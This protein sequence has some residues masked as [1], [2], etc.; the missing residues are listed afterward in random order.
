MRWIREYP[1]YFHLAKFEI[2]ISVIATVRSIVKT[3]LKGDEERG[4][5]DSTLHMWRF[6]LDGCI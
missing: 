6:D 4:R 1:I 5:R 2:E 3:F